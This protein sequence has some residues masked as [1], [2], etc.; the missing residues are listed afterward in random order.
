MER[1]K[2]VAT[3]L[4]SVL[5]GGGG[6]RRG[7]AIC[8]QLIVGLGGHPIGGPSGCHGARGGLRGVPRC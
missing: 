7:D 4:V 6:A 1:S 5:L 2:A 8:T 3:A